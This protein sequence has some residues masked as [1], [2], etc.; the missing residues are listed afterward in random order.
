M[1]LKSSVDRYGVVAIAVHWVTAAVVLG[2]LVAGT[3]AA[4]TDDDTTRAA[5][6]RVH[7]PLGILIVLLTVFRIVWWAVFD[8]KPP[9]PA[10]AGPAQRL[11]LKTVHALFYVAIIVMGASG[12]GMMVLSGAGE[13]LF[14]G[15]PGP[16][17]DF[18]RFPPFYGHAI[19]AV[20]LVTLLVG[21]VGAALW[22]QLVK[23]DHLLARMGV[24]TADPRPPAVK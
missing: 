18:T 2:L 7:A 15:K 3:M 24:G 17:P 9:P 20:L 11:G 23:R 4:I 6:L 16:L 1:A 22:H 10:D 21:H 13:I 5:I 19:G 14:G 8:R 12:I